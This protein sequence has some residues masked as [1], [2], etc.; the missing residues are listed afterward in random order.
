MSPRTKGNSDNYYEYSCA[1]QNVRGLKGDDKIE[2]IVESIITNIVD[3]FLLQETWMIGNITQNLRECA[4]FYH[5]LNKSLIHIGERGV[6]I[7]L[8]PRFNE[9]YENAGGLPPITTS[10]DGDDFCGG[11]CL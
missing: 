8:S 11:R 5:G 9:F 7:I 6:A 4:M 2:G 10:N 1:S 3:V